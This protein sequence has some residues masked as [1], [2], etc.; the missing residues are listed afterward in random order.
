MLSTA[1]IKLSQPLAPTLFNEDKFGAAG[2][3]MQPIDK[4]HRWQLVFRPPLML[5]AHIFYA[6]AI[7][8][9]Y[10]FVST[11]SH[12]FS[13]SITTWGCCHR[14]RDV[15]VFYSSAPLAANKSSFLPSIW[16]CV[17]GGRNQYHAW[18]QHTRALDLRCR[19]LVA[20]ILIRKILAP[21]C[22]DFFEL[23]LLFN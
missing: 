23:F 17:C 1:G 4:W 11:I 21:E 2:N 8:T 3:K 14:E 19:M 18:T 15:F 20:F 5:D 9:T 10:V 12:S 16:L 7:F 6:S 22:N 13:S